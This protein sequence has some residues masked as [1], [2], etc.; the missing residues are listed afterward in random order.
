M[1]LMLIELARN[2]RAAPPEMIETVACTI[3]DTDEDIV[4]EAIADHVAKGDTSWLEGRHPRL[5]WEQ[6]EASVQ[7]AYRRRARA[8]ISVLASSVRPT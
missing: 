6:V 5:A 4:D 3:Y 1:S 8:A 2:L 7:E